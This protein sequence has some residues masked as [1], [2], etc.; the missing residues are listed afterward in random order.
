MK[1][2]SLFF[3]L[4][5]PVMVMAQDSTLA[6]WLADFPV[7]DSLVAVMSDDDYD[8][9]RRRG[10]D[11]CPEISLADLP[12]AEGYAYPEAFW[13]DPFKGYSFEQLRNGAI[14]VSCFGSFD[15]EYLLLVFAND[16]TLVDIRYLKAALGDAGA[17]D[18]YGCY[19]YRKGKFFLWKVYESEFN[20][21]R[22][23]GNKRDSTLSELKILPTGQYDTLYFEQR[24]VRDFGNGRR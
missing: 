15:N 19:D 21:G 4:A 13:N 23:Y 18:R 7:Q 12:K 9:F 3:L 8:R 20:E 11:D 6:R 14:L 10:C 16:S 17:Q 2:V 24:T 5:L 22:K 1:K